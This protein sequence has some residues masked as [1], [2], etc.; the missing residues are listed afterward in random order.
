MIITK[1]DISI[2]GKKKFMMGFCDA[3][4]SLD[5]RGRFIIIC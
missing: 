1:T 2:R 3:K 5:I 4:Y